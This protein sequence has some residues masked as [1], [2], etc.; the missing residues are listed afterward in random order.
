MP[1][2]M[3]FLHISSFAECFRILTLNQALPSGIIVISNSFVSFSPFSQSYAIKV[4][5]KV[6]AW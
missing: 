4:D 5:T 6:S 3:P 1:L 2:M